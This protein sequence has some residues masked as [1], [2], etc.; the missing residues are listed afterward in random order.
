MSFSNYKKFENVGIRSSNDTLIVMDSSNNN[1]SLHSSDGGDDNVDTLSIKNI[2]NK[3]PNMDLNLSSLN[4]NVINPVITINN[5]NQDCRI[6][7]NLNVNGNIN[8]TNGGIMKTTGI[9]SFGSINCGVGTFTSLDSGSGMVKTTGQGSFGSINC[10]VGTFTSLNST[11]DIDAGSN[12]V[13]GGTISIKDHIYFDKYNGLTLDCPTNPNNF[14]VT[15]P[16]K[17]CTLIGTDNNNLDLGSD[18]VTTTGSIDCSSIT[19]SGSNFLIQNTTSGGNITIDNQDADK[20]II[21]KLGTN[22]T[23]TSFEVQ[24]SSGVAHLYVNG[25][26]EVGI[27]K[28]NPNYKLD[29]NG[30]VNASSF[31]GT[32]NG[33]YVSGAVANA[34]RAENLGGAT[35]SQYHLMTSRSIVERDGSGGFGAGVITFPAQDYCLNFGSSGAQRGRL[36][37]N[38][39]TGYK[40][41]IDYIGDTYKCNTSRYHAF[42]T[43]VG[44]NTDAP[45]WPID[46]RDGTTGG[47]TSSMWQGGDGSFFSTYK[48]SEDGDRGIPYSAHWSGTGQA[49]TGDL[50]FDASDDGGINYFYITAHFQHSTW[51]S[52]GAYMHSSDERIK[53]N[54]KNLNDKLALDIITKIETKSYNY[55]DVINR[56]TQQVIGFIAQNVRE[57]YPEA[58]NITTKIIPNVMKIINASWISF[59]ENNKTKYKMTTNDLSD[60]SNIKYKFY[61]SDDNIDVVPEYKIKTE[62]IDIIGNSDN[63]FTFEK[64]WTNVFC[65][66]KEVDDFHTIDK[67]KIFV[68]H[69]SGIQ[70]LDRQ[71]IAD[72][73]R[74]TNLETKVNTLETANQQQQTKINTLKTEN[75]ELKSI[76]DKLKTANSFEE[77]KNSL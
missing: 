68:L 21:M 37:A 14:N 1:I 59:T 35:P 43:R 64:Q 8:L 58:V 33:G 30:A 77:F 62:Q 9:G 57:Y 54:I 63:T 49:G 60:I 28:S 47:V 6:M 45:S 5:N 10:G 56:G 18:S 11:G 46:V 23:A 55:R 27:G 34:T 40:F 66:G 31:I 3:T 7:T 72:K 15:L 26:G 22:T 4:G 75:A 71:Q 53:C 61:V 38:G 67:D 13:I 17:D 29:V 2:I 41:H 76:I 32:I 48:G 70:E 20:K 51:V 19:T 44:I 65:Y 42:Y 39:S 73:E 50:D 25:N 69:H 52:D 24:N 16:N 74:I 12:S 36:G